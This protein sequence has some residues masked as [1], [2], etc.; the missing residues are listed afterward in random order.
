MVGLKLRVL[1]AA[2]YLAARRLLS[3]VVREEPGAMVVGEAENSSRA[4]ALAR[5]LR[6][7]VTLLDC[8]L[9]Q[10]QGID[11]N[12]LS[13]IAGLDT[14]LV[15]TQEVRDMQAIVLVNLNEAILQGEALT[16]ALKVCF[17]KEEG[18]SA[19][20][21]T[22]H[23]LHQAAPLLANPVFANVHLE[24]RK[25]TQPKL[26]AMAED[27]LSVS[28]L[29]LMGGLILIATFVLA[30][31]G[32]IVALAGLGGLLLSLGM[33]AVAWVWPK[34]VSPSEVTPASRSDPHDLGRQVVPIQGTWDGWKNGNG[35][36]KAV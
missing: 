15:I 11:S 24:E 17:Q 31:I 14:A 2:E 12:R 27:V 35:H 10:T 18:A 8:H 13:R 9:P 16:L 21:F 20:A 6:P 30:P 1:V 19:V 7:D 33:R 23:Q 26:A 3:D 29:T 4:I 25:A 34:Q 32:A 28:G 5:T 22:L 36:K